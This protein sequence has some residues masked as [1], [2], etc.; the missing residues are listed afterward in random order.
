MEQVNFFLW[1][2]R[3]QQVID[4]HYPHVMPH[5]SS[6]SFWEKGMTS[7]MGKTFLIGKF[8]VFTWIEF[9]VLVLVIYLL[10]PTSQVIINSGIPAKW[11]GKIPRKLSEVQGPENLF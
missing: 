7:D 4:G 1:R 11:L 9:T 5:S 10:F 3:S 6:L 8:Y 2:I